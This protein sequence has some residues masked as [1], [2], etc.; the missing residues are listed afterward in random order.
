MIY[1]YVIGHEQPSGNFGKRNSDDEKYELRLR[2]WCS[3]L[4]V[5]RQA[6]AEFAPLLY[7]AA[8]FTFNFGYLE[9]ERTAM[10][11]TFFKM[12]MLWKASELLKENLQQCTIKVE[13][14]WQP[15]AASMVYV[16]LNH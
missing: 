13:A 6:Y 5:C 14:G 3:L 1:R 4:L 11:Q 16:L 15:D 2:R 9:N 7:Q 10:A 12:S 8:H